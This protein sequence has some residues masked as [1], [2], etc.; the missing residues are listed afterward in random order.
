MY[1][2]VLHVWRNLH[3]LQQLPEPS[4][5]R[6]VWQHEVDGLLRVL[7][8]SRNQTVV[9]TQHEVTNLRAALRKIEHRLDANDSPASDDKQGV[10]QEPLSQQQQVTLLCTYQ[11]EC[12][13]VIVTNS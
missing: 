2:I 9:R 12:H 10:M 7:L 4:D 5:S 8:L 13:S 6:Q 11:C 3:L 1:C